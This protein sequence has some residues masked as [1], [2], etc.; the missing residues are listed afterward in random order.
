MGNV[1]NANFLPLVGCLFHLSQSVLRKVKVLG[2]SIPYDKVPKCTDF[3]N[4]LV[5]LAFVPPE[6]VVSSFVVLAATCPPR[7]RPVKTYF[8]VLFHNF[9]M[10]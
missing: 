6:Q 4:S 2:L 5:A 1:I 7:M 9:A 10:L 8:E 3:V